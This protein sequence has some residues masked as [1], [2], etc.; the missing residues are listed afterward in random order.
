MGQIIDVKHNSMF[1]VL[2]DFYG[3]KNGRTRIS[4]N[5]LV[6]FISNV[7]NYNVEEFGLFIYII[8]DMRARNIRSISLVSMSH[9]YA[10]ALE[11]ICHNTELTHRELAKECYGEIRRYIK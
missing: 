2:I 7:L 9:Y 3:I 10:R 6:Y 1:K 11:Q 8:K 5:K 4:I